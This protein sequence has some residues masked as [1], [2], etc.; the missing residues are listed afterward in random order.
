MTH[1][2]LTFSQQLRG[3]GKQ[4]SFLREKLIPGRWFFAGIF[5]LMQCSG[6]W[7]EGKRCCRVRVEVELSHCASSWSQADCWEHWR[8]PGSRQLCSLQATIKQELLFST[9]RKGQCLCTSS[10]PHGASGGEGAWC[11]SS[12]SRGRRRESCSF[13]VLLYSPLTC[14]EENTGNT[15]TSD[16][17]SCYLDA[18]LNSLPQLFWHKSCVKDSRAFRYL[19]ATLRVG[20]LWSPPVTPW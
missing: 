7:G 9:R 12:A 16:S 1:Q 13:A 10:L 2:L 17:C 4:S 6:L 11:C 20:G 14:R 18:F 5:E 3:K 19:I 8:S 15:S